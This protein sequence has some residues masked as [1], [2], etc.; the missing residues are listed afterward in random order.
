VQ[1]I[2]VHLVRHGRV[3]SHRG[4][5]PLTDEGLAEIERAG[6]RLARQLEPGERVHVLYSPT[7]RSRDTAGV[8]YATLLRAVA[9]DEGVELSPPAEEWAIRNPDVFVAGRR[10][11]MVSTAEALAAQIPETGL[12]A[13]QI[14]ALPFYREFFRHPD[15]I[16]Y[17]VA[18]PNPPG[19]TSEAVA[20][21]VMSYAISLSD[22]PRDRL[23]RF[24]C[25]THSPIMRAVLCCYLLPEDP[26][27][28]EWVESIDLRIESDGKAEI[29]FRD[30]CA[31]I[32]TGLRDEEGKK[33]WRIDSHR[34]R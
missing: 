24:I 6:K 7:L 5:V 14:D 11:E 23:W 20:R 29:H 25:V 13:E 27:E 19:E 32:L 21:R 18:D 9:A 33:P 17:W 10:V 8:L 2:L 15:R 16:G 4:D 1:P 22:L 12:T 26:G 28:P 31:T 34:S 30:A 3:A